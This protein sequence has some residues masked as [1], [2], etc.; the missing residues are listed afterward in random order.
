MITNKGKEIV[1]KYLLGTAPA[2]AS[3]MAFGSGPQPL[4]S[5]DS[6]SFNTYKEKE[7]LDFEMFRVPISSKGYVYEDG[8]NKLVF[9]AELPSQERYE[10]TEIGIYS[11]GSNPSAA[12]FDSRNII[13]F[14]QE[15]S[16]QS[17]TGSTSSIPVITVPL[18]PADNNVIS[19]IIDSQ[20]VDVF[21][22]NA[23]NR[24]FYN[25]NRNDYHERCRFFNNVILV[26][27]D[28]SSIKDATSSTDLSSAY[29]LLKTG[30]STDLS[31]NSLSDKIKIAFSVI[32][33]SASQILST[34]YTGPDSVKIIIDFI[35]TSTKKARLIYNVINTG[36]KSVSNKELTSNVATL[37]TSSAHSFS[38]GDKVLITGVDNTFNG[39]YVIT[40]TTSTTFSYSK[41][42]D[43]VSSTVVSPVGQVVGIDFSTNRYYAVEKN[44]SDVVQEDGFSWADITSIKIYSCAVT[45]NALDDNYYIGLD[46]IR[47]ENVSTQNPLYGLTGYTIVKNINEQ[48]V[49]KGSNTNNYVEYRMTVGV[50]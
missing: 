20:E 10:I 16:W 34:P 45:S 30:M 17:V 5:S 46:A 1:A 13:L 22:A 39:T 7:C 11:A 6:H 24:I 8:V 31:Q 50:E 2:Y 23:D 18:D 29:H 41:T 38:V 4:G 33:K 36:T 21:Q 48:P 28:F 15:E 14:S 3:Y 9:T 27:G 12:G 49:L 25:K 47:V 43:N 26:A 35:N 40:S 37:T 32:N 19:V 44:I 42:A